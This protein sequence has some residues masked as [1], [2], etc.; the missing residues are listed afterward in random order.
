MNR[1]NAYRYYGASKDE[2]ITGLKKDGLLNEVSQGDQEALSV[3]YPGE[4]GILRAARFGFV[5][6][7]AVILTVGYTLF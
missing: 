3:A 6:L 2:I 7:M 1:K 5:A 4:K